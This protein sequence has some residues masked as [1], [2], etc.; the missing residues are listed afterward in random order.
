MT[1]GILITDNG[2]ASLQ[3]Q[4][5]NFADLFERLLNG[6]DMAFEYRHYSVIDGEFPVSPDEC[7]AWLIT[8]S[9]HGVYD[10][11]PWMEPLRALIRTL[12][13]EKRP[14]VGICFGHQIIAEA[15]GGRVEKFDGGWNLGIKQYQ[16]TEQ[17]PCF[18]GADNRAPVTEFAINAI[19]QDQ[20]LDIPIGCRVF[21][22][23][24]RCANA[25][26][27]WGGHILTFQGH[28]EFYRQ[29]E[30]DLLTADLGVTFPDRELQPALN[31]LTEDALDDQQVGQWIARFIQLGVSC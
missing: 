13:D 10:D 26:L 5:G 31:S 24:P 15:L 12:H 8:G 25:G 29:Y 3:E 27:V 6:S 28:P 4:H 21:A 30:Q 11:L 22:S 17:L 19:H 23:A 16:V 14:L 18:S 20:V 2:P 1:L 9:A 7:Q